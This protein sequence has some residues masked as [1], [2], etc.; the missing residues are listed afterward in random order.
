MTKSRCQRGEKNDYHTLKK[1]QTTNGFE[2]GGKNDRDRHSNTLKH[3][4]KTE[5]ANQR[6]GLGESDR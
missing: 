2:I 6:G 5:K 4:K 3:R 1:T